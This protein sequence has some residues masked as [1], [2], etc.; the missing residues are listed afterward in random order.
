MSTA[1]SVPGAVRGDGSVLDR[2]PGRAALAAIAA[3]TLLSVLIALAQT[4]YGTLMSDLGLDGG[5]AYGAAAVLG[6]FDAVFVAVGC[7]VAVWLCG[8]ALRVPDNRLSAVL[9]L[10]SGALL[11]ATVLEAAAVLVELLATGHAPTLLALSPARWT[12][13]P[14]LGGLSFSNLLMFTALWLGLVRG[15]RWPG[16]KAAVPVVL[17]LAVAAVAFSLS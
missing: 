13:V 5:T 16:G 3:T 11:A 12:G 14:A 1:F 7:G 9:A 2:A 17:L 10:T 8:A 6:V 4:G 15:L